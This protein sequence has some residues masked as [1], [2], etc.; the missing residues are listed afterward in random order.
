MVKEVILDIKQNNSILKK[1]LPWVAIA[2]LIAGAF[3]IIGYGIGNK[4]EFELPLFQEETPTKS[5]T[6]KNW[7]VHETKNFSIEYPRDW[8]VKNNAKDEPTG[9]KVLGS[10]GKVEFWFMEER[11]YKFTPDQKEKQEKSTNSKIKIDGRN[12]TLVE[13]PFK[14]GGI[15][16]V[17][18]LPKTDKKPKV[19][20][21]INASNKNFRNTAVEIIST[22]KTVTVSGKIGQFNE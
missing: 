9:A 1:Y 18:Q 6:K 4:T 20:F 2:G 12:T 17:A 21:W 8:E 16:M 15:F 11:V 7:Y 13:Y 19:I 5:A 3:F 10:G 14:E 22:Y